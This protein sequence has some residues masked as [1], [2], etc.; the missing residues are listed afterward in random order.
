MSGVNR[1]VGLKTEI[2]GKKGSEIGMGWRRKSV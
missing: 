2:V 1:K